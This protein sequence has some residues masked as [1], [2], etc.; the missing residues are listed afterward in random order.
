MGLKRSVSPQR[1]GAGLCVLDL[2]ALVTLQMSGHIIVSMTGTP[3]IVQ[4]TACAAV[5]GDPDLVS[6]SQ[7]ESDSH[8]PHKECCFKAVL[9]SWAWLPRPL[10][11]LSKGRWT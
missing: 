6:L 7:E 5:C 10:L 9:S 2:P 1:G 4:C 3:R 8:F 11:Y